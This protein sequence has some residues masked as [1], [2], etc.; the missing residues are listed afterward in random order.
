MADPKGHIQPTLVI[1][2]FN[3]PDSLRR[4]LL[5]LNQAHFPASVRLHISL[6]P[7]QDPETQKVAEEFEWEG[8]KVVE[9]HPERLGLRRHLL[10]CGGLAR[11]YGAVIVMEDDLMV[12][13][14]FYDYAVQALQFSSAHPRLAGI[15]LYHYQKTEHNHAPFYPWPDDTDNYYLQWP[16]SWGQAWTATQWEG[17]VEWL[18]KNESDAEAHLP[19]YVQTWE[20]DSWKRLF[21]A[22]VI[23]TDRYFLYPR[24][25][26]STHFGEPGTHTVERGIHQSPLLPG[27]REWNFTSLEESPAVY[28]AWFEMEPDCLRKLV[29]GLP[30]GDVGVDLYGQKE[31]KAISNAFVLT[32]K[33]VEAEVQWGG[34]LVPQEMN[35]VLGV[36]G[37]ELSWVETE[38]IQDWAPLEEKER[39]EVSLE[40]V[41]VVEKWSGAAEQSLAS[42]PEEMRVVVI[43]E[44]PETFRPQ[45]TWRPW[46]GRQSF[47]EVLVEAFRESNADYVGWLQPGDTLLADFAAQFAQLAEDNPF[48]DWFLLRRAGQSLPHFRWTRDRFARSHADDLTHQLGPGALWWKRPFWRKL[49][50]ETGS[51]DAVLAAAF[52]AALPI[53]VDWVGYQSDRAW[54]LPLREA[55]RWPLRARRTFIG[56]WLSCW[57]RPVFLEDGHYR[58]V[59]AELEQYPPVIRWQA[60]ERRWV[61]SRF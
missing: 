16:S 44:V 59:H 25:S 11:K 1:P 33:S 27:G 17:F 56:Q 50:V 49:E 12:A 39:G 34:E 38:T 35:L 36:E 37:K 40:V 23:A 53:P 5:N 8:E 41:M 45:V 14:H 55:A 42:V 19:N 3:R 4:L 60:E 30:E 20:G 61:Q 22:Y 10:Y 2:A 6:D 15:S 52:Q 32:R 7:S 26:L 48:V 58:W 24:Y 54:N 18:E 47:L 57:F 31:R 9:V 29:P 21:I 43:G 51:W 46:P 28:D 13:P